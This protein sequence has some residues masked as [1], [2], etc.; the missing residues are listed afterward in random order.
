MKLELEGPDIFFAF[1][2]G[3]GA[4]SILKQ[5]SKIKGKKFHRIKARTNIITG[6]KWVRVRA[7]KKESK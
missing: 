3:L 4:L 1:V 2:L 6:E 7:P 5:G